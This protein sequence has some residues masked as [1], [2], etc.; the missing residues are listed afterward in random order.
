M[1]NSASDDADLYIYGLQVEEGSYATSYIP[2]Y[3]TS[4]TR[5]KDSAVNSPSF[6]FGSG[7]FTLFF[8][9]EAI[10]TGSN[11]Q[12]LL[13]AVNPLDFYFRY[14]SDNIVNIWNQ[15]AQTK[16]FQG[17]LNRNQNHKIITFYLINFVNLIWVCL[18]R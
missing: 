4:V 10:P 2:T 7:A 13:L 15:D 18:I 3:G 9:H 14:T 12:V 11:G 5:N 8:E 1:R 17:S 16:I 6:S